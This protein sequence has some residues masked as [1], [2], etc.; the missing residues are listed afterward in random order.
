MPIEIVSQ[1]KTLV[2]SEETTTLKRTKYRQFDE[3]AS[4]P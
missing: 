1:L 2:G 4:L 3:V